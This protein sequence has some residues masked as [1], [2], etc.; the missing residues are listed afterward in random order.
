MSICFDQTS[1]ELKDPLARW[2][3]HS[4]NDENLVVGNDD[5][6]MGTAFGS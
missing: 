2:L 1:V 6:L 4:T 5:G 3:V